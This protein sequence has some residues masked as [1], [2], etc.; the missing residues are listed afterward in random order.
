MTGGVCSGRGDQEETECEGTKTDFY[1]VILH[2][3]VFLFY[4]ANFAS[5]NV[6]RR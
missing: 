3:L 5:P 4:S 6:V 2:K 1:L